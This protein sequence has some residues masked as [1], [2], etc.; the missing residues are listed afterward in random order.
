MHW[1]EKL[2]KHKDFPTPV[3]LDFAM[4]LKPGEKKRLR[5]LV[6]ESDEEFEDD[7]KR[8]KGKRKLAAKTAVAKKPKTA[9]KKAAGI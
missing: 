8:V 3:L 2:G 9:A 5:E 7:E 4:K 6:D 1:H